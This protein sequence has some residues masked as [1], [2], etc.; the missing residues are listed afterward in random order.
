VESG[1]VAAVEEGDAG[2]MIIRGTH[3]SR[4]NRAGSFL[5]SWKQP[6]A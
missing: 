1:L 6:D 3:A 2:A 4:A 5:V